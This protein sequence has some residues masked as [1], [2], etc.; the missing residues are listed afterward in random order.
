MPFDDK[1]M[2]GAFRLP[3][4]LKW[5]N[6]YLIMIKLA[7]GLLIILLT[8][9][10]WL[11][12]Q[13]ELDEQRLTLVADVLWLEQSINFHLVGVAENLGQLSSD[14]PRDE[15]PHALFRLRCDYLLKNNPDILRIAWV[16]ETGAL[17]ESGPVSGLFG[18]GVEGGMEEARF[19]ENMEMAHK[20]GKPVFT[21]AYAI[22]HDVQFAIHSP[23]FDD[24]HYRGT[25]IGVFSLNALLRDQVPWWFV[26]KYQ[27]SL[28]NGE[29]ETLAHRSK[30]ADA[31]TTLSYSI[32]LDPPG[33]G[34]GIRV[35]AYRSSG[36]FVKNTLT[37]S[38]IALA[39]IVLFSLRVMRGHVRR[40]IDAEQAHR[41][42]YAFRKAMED[43]LKVG[44][45]AR[46]L[47]GKVTYVNP[48]F[49]QMF[50]FSEEEL[51]GTSLPQPYWA[52][53]EMERTQAIHDRVIAGEVPKEGIELRMMRKDGRRLDVL[54]YEAPLIDA[55]GQHT[56][57]MASL[58]DITARRQ[59]EDLARQQQEKLQATSRLVTMGEM[60]STLA[61][62]LNQPLAAITSYAAGCVNRLESGNFSVDD[63]RVALTKLGAQAQRAGRII[64]RVHDFVR[65]SEP[66]LIPHDLAE[67]IDDAVGL[68]EPTAR[69]A[70]VRIECDIPADVPRLKLDQVMIE[71]ILLN[72]MRNAI[73]AMSAPFPPERRYLKIKVGRV[74]DQVH[75]RVIDRG[76]GI[77]R[78]VRDRLF[79]PFFSTK[80]EGM[81][82][83]LNICRSIIE[84]HRGRLW[85]EENPEGGA[86]VVISLPGGAMP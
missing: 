83:G 53:E 30:L 38:V 79:T 37:A 58:I 51:L 18:L 69:L 63:L 39:M 41:W 84:F 14:L 43:S 21:D 25:L 50:G 11:L 49:C 35:E 17:R 59:A 26:E 36:N 42:E 5:S 7:V 20:L 86:I 82:M 9:L 34:I 45:R 81:G 32:P 33:F 77:S 44:M 71:Q 46:D 73:E 29:G 60:A 47:A 48:A 72:V 67:V 62:E 56:G 85:I 8:A 31:E 64:R 12:H 28:V 54:I 78:E 3:S 4:F 2:S 75:I 40:R 23:V 27:V 19:R 68:I 1:P 66:R 15:D 6:R 80:T 16:D 13:S 10:F 76:T 22:A 65:K 55:D 70:R 24:G 57:W 74:G 52:P 61:H